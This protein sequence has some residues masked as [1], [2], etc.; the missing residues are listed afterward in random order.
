MSC[1][2]AE[3]PPI[4]RASWHAT[5]LFML[6][7]A[8]SLVSIGCRQPSQQEIYPVEG[9]LTVNGAP[10][11]NASLGFHPLDRGASARCPVGRTDIHG[12]FH[13]TTHSYCDGAPAG[14]YAVTIVWPDESSMVDECN[15]PD[16]LQHDRLNGLYA[17]AEQ[18]EIRVTVE[19][20]AKS[21]R[22][23]AWQPRGRPASLGARWSNFGFPTTPAK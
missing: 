18:T 2:Q 16:P 4:F 10:A 7:A 12:R 13:L 5:L 19:R 3:E 1:R 6:F 22:L 8:A 17:N 21:F 14:E 23:D 9:I 11:A 15:C 20:S